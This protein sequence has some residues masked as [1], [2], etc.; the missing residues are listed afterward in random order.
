MKKRMINTLVGMM[1]LLLA[2]CAP[3]K[4]ETV[5]AQGPEPVVV[6]ENQPTNLPAPLE[7]IPTVAPK[8]GP[9]TED[10]SEYTG[11]TYSLVPEHLSQG[12][13][14]VIFGKDAYGLTMI[15]DGEQKMLWLEKILDYDET[16]NAIWEVKDVLMLSHLEPG[17]TLIPDGCFLNGTPDSE[18]LVVGKNGVIRMAWRANT[19]VEKFEAIVADGITCNSDKAMPIN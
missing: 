6:V 11:L 19:T 17:L 9:D 15:I 18:I 8:E 4:S 10:V 14:M 1:I 13:S 3:F 2:A 16:G 12:F 5:P 7:S